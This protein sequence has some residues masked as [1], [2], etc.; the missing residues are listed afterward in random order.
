MS[1]EG[2]AEITSAVAQLLESVQTL[3]LATLNQAGQPL[4]SYAPFIHE[5][6]Q[7]F[8]IFVSELAGHTRNLLQRP[9]AGVLIIAD[10]AVSRQPFARERLG[11]ECRAEFISRHTQA[12]APLLG[13]FEEKFGAVL[14]L[15]KNLKDFHLI[16]LKPR[17][18][19]YVRGFGEA[20][21]FEGATLKR[22]IHI[23]SERISRPAGGRPS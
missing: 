15:L 10:E 17:R 4:A 9:E 12:W 23:D 8:Y 18:G 20:W 14:K 19:I 13:C 2:K 5:P 11:F 3:Q 16:A 22:F 1:P 21:S 7:G 6:G